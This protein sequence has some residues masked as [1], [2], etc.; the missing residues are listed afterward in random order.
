M[1]DHKVISCLD[2]NAR[3]KVPANFSGKKVKCSKCG[4]IIE[5]DQAAAAPTP[6]AEKAGAGR[7]RRSATP[8]KA[9][10]PARRSSRAKASAEGE[11]ASAEKPGR[12]GRRTRGAAAAAGKGKTRAS[13]RGAASEE[14][15]EKTAGRTR[16][17]ASG[18]RGRRAA[19]ASAE[20]SGPNVPLLAGIGVVVIAAIVVVV[21]MMM[22][23]D[24]PIPNE[25][26]S[27]ESGGTEATG[28]DQAGAGGEGASSEGGEGDAADAGKTTKKDDTPV[29]V[30]KEW[31]PL[32]HKDADYE[33]FVVQ[34]KP[35]PYLK[36]TPADVIE[37][38]ESLQSVVQDPSGGREQLGAVSELKSYGK[39]AVAALINS[40]NG[41]DMGKEAHRIVGRDLDNAI[42]DILQKGNERWFVEPPA[43]EDKIK[44]PGGIET[45]NQKAVNLWVT[46][47]CANAR[48][49]GFWIL[50]DERHKRNSE[51]AQNEGDG[52]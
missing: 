37:K 13:K 42:Y 44:V 23:D 29:Y 14:G 17:S 25:T 1:A 21:M 8:P 16:R 49:P 5:L 46:F 6:P 50:V 47:Y 40:F 39:Y 36:D 48:N 10:K 52:E 30:P 15:E 35:V 43:P 3:F 32:F 51:A 41:L 4:A 27:A 26:K 12:A 2:C 38:M 11:D 18:G 22:S 34:I 45:Y 31:D 9:E 19:A 20:S 24:E 28:A 7:A 33:N